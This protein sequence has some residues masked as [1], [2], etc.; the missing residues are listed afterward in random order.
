V[1]DALATAMVGDGTWYERHH[2]RWALERA[3]HRDRA[4]DVGMAIADYAHAATCRETRRAADELKGTGDP[5]V[6]ALAGDPRYAMQRAC[7]QKP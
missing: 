2:A 1:I 5:R 3:G 6:A 4:D 7:L